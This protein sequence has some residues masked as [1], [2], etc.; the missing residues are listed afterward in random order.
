MITKGGPLNATMVLV[1]HLF[2]EAFRYI[3][4]GYAAALSCVLLALILALAGV[5]FWLLR[6]PAQ[7]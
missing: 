3:H 7:A 6:E 4:I 1:Y 2:R 5:Q